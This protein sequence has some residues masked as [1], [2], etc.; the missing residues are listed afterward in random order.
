M[1]RI[2]FKIL[3][4]LVAAFLLYNL[5]VLGHIVYWRDHNPGASSFMNE[6]LARL[7]Q[8]DP[9]AE[10]RHKWV[11]YDKISPNLKRAL[12]AS[13]DARFVDHEGFDWDG[14]EAAFEKNLKKGKIVAGGS[15]ISQ[16]LA[17]NLFLS[18]GKTPWRKLEEAL[19]T[20]ML[21]TVL[22]KRRIYEIYLNVIEWGNGVFG[23]EAA[24]RYYF[25][26][27]A[28]RLSSSQAAKLA[29]MVP[30]PR[31]YDE[32]RNAPGLARKTR[33]IQRRMAYVELP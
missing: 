7:Q 29:A 15:T 25:R 28:S 5:W 32:H 6:Q 10:L 24:S 16:Q 30:N 18:S 1:S 21:E 33:I 14:I 4:A 22:D 20:V 12:I 19:I 9:E 31:Y 13:E 17:K 2:L 26:T 27:G 3:A 8:D 11:P 23:A